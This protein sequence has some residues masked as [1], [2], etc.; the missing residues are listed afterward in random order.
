MG[1]GGRRESEIDQSSEVIITSD[2][3]V[4]L[5]NPL[6][7]LVLHHLRLLPASPCLLLSPFLTWGINIYNAPL[8]GITGLL[9]HFHLK[10]T[11]WN[12]MHTN[13]EFVFESFRYHYS[14]IWSRFTAKTKITNDANNY[15]WH[16]LL[17]VV[18]P[19]IDKRTWT[20]LTLK[21]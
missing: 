11:P 8:S 12:G 4:I 1:K 18:V 6:S 10:I 3:C 20:W 5:W 2:F 21:M 16:K 17:F 7:P 13:T 15:F 9:I 14:E 19:Q